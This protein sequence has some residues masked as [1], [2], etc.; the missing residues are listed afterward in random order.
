VK[1]PFSDD[2]EYVIKAKVDNNVNG[3]KISNKVDGEA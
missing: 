1:G 3:E 2:Q